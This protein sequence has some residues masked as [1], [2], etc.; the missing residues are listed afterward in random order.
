VSVDFGN[1]AQPGEIRGRNF[2]DADG[3]GV[4]DADEP[5]LSGWTMYLD[6]NH[7]GSLD[8]GEYWVVTDESGDFTFSDLPAASR[9]TVA[10]IAAEDWRQTVPNE[11]YFSLKDL[12]PV[13][14]E[15]SFTG[16]E[17]RG[18]GLNTSTVSNAG[19][20]NGDGFDDIIIGAYQGCVTK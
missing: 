1:Q 11:S 5:G 4:Q 17:L 3:D 12:Q 10:Q 19:D 2:L 18:S 16:D 6:Q 20:F 9:Y 8:A 7:D 13:N 15:G 14:R